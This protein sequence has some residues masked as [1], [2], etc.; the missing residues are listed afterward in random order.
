[1]TASSYAQLPRSKPSAVMDSGGTSTS[2]AT[3]AMAVHPF[4]T[5]Q[6]G[7]GNISAFA[8]RPSGSV[9]RKNP[10][11]LMG[12]FL[13]AVDSTTTSTSSANL[14]HVKPRNSAT[15]SCDLGTTTCSKDNNNDESAT[16]GISRA[17]S[18]R[19]LAS[20]FER[21]SAPSTLQH[22]NPNAILLRSKKTT[23][24]EVASN[25]ELL[26][27]EANE[28]LQH[29]THAAPHH[30]RDDGGPAVSKDYLMELHRKL[31]GRWNLLT[32]IPRKHVDF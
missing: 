15:P 1:M 23:I 5:L 16:A 8:T 11:P 22:N 10:P 18:L 30:A 20:K 2:S 21:I 28:A 4:A 9:S 32:K 6:R 14:P 19:D 13:A 29:Q 24:P 31:T 7:G 26:E 25:C 3:S 12:T 27:S 17:Q